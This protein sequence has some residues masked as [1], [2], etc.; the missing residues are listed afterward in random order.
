LNKNQS[1]FG[2]LS[3]KVKNEKIEDIFQKIYNQKDIQIINQ[4]KLS[5][6]QKIGLFGLSKMTEEL[7]TDDLVHLIKKL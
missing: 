1:D 4:L 3:S 7:S 2:F 5:D 6:E